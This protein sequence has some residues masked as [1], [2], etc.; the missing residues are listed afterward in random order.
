MPRKGSALL[1]HE[2]EV[3]LADLLDVGVL[4]ASG[5]EPDVNVGVLD[6]ELLGEISYLH[7]GITCRLKGGKDLVLQT[8]AGSTLRL[9][10]GFRNLCRTASLLFGGAATALALG[11]NADSLAGKERGELSLNLLDFGKKGFLAF[12]EFDQVAK[13]NGIDVC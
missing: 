13:G 4:F 2:F 9:A 5:A 12:G 10:S 11:D 3:P 6:A 7:S 1:I 8:A